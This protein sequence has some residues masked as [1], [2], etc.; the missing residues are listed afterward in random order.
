M[1][2]IQQLLEEMVRRGASDLHL[3][4]GVPPIL[5]LDGDLVPTEHEVLKPETTQQLAYSLM[6][7]Q[8]KKKFEQEKELDFSYSLPGVSRFRGN[9]LLQRGT[10]GAVFRAVPAR[11]LTLDELGLPAILK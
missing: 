5:R 9:A 4:A 3:T 6:N 2:T 7:D 1:T 8:Q 11:P 10:V